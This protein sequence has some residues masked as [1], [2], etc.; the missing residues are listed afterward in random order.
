M[1]TCQNVECGKRI[2]YFSKFYHCQ[3]CEKNI[4]KE[5]YRTPFP[6]NPGS[7][8]HGHCMDCRRL[9]SEDPTKPPSAQ[10]KNPVPNDGNVIST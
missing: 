10:V 4:C 3:I 5:C 1:N 2:S 6:I 9:L 7:I 8:I